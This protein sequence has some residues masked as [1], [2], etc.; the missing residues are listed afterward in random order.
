MK[1]VLELLRIIIIFAILGVVAW[2][3]LGEVYAINT[4][5]QKYQWIGAIG[6]YTLL[7]VFYRNKLQFSGWYKGKGREKLP[8][9]ITVTL[10]C[11]S[12]VL[13]AAPIIIGWMKC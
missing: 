8:K 2:L 10:I 5:I 11:V 6:I 12:I 4:T 3:L 13:L 1:V 9:K 7:F